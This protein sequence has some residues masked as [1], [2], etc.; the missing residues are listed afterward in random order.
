MKKNNFHNRYQPDFTDFLNELKSR[1]D[2]KRQVD[3]AQA[4]GV[5]QSIISRIYSYKLPNL[6]KQIPR[7]EKLNKLNFRDLNIEIEK[8]Y[9][10]SL[11]EILTNYEKN[12]LLKSESLSSMAI[13]EKSQWYYR[14]NPYLPH[15]K[16]TWTFLF[17]F[18]DV[19]Q[20]LP[21]LSLYLPCNNELGF[22]K[23]YNLEE[24][25]LSLKFRYAS[26]GDWI[27]V[28]RH[29]SVKIEFS[30]SCQFQRG[31][32]Y[33]WELDFYIDLESMLS[34]YPGDTRSYI[35]REVI[36]SISHQK[37][38]TDFLEGHFIYE[39]K[40]RKNSFIVLNYLPH[41]MEYTFLEDED[42]EERIH[43]LE[44]KK[45]LQHG[46]RDHFLTIIFHEIPHSERNRT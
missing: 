36:Q 16:C 3:L 14:T 33:G 32:S 9:P 6:K 4:L 44:W 27:P 20:E 39:I 7:I 40:E 26:D 45:L 30:E 21:K 31:V 24:R 37:M 25:D 19:H 23:L 34:S 42:L 46:M 13:I 10:F 11:Q 12:Q 35:H 17:H 2:L 28:P 41:G 22:S 5:S 38:P 43:R 8:N 18:S 1:H 29:Y 15:L